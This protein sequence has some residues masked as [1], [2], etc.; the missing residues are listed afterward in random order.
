VNST[1][2]FGGSTARPLAVV[3]VTLASGRNVTIPDPVVIDTVAPTIRLGEVHHGPAGLVIHY[4]RSRGP[5]KSLL[6]VSQNGA[7]VTSRRV[8]PRVCHLRDA[9]LTPGRYTVSIVGVDRAGNR[10]PAPPSFELTVP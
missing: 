8:L 6:V 10:T 3:R 1:D 7:V 9:D 5:G 2:L 4:T